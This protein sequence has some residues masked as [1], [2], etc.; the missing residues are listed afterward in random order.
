M[1]DETW[2]AKVSPEIKEELVQLVKESGLSSKEF[3]EQLLLEH[4]VALLQGTDA[5]RSED[6]QQVSYHLEKIKA[7]FVGLVEKSQDLKN[8]FNET[9]ERESRLHKEI[10]DQ[11]QYQVKQ[12][13]EERDKVI[14]DKSELEKRM[15]GIVARNEEL[16]SNNKAHLLTIQMQEEKIGQL[17]DR[18]G[19]IQAIE[20]EV[21]RLNQ[22]VQAQIKRIQDLEKEAQQYKREMEQA[23]AAKEV[24]E[25]DAAKA[26]EQ[27]AMSHKLELQSATLELE[28]RLHEENHKIKVEYF[29]KIETLTSKNQELTEKLHQLQLDQTKVKTKPAAVKEKDNKTEEGK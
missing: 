22:D 1:A 5:Q 19:A 13:Q 27:Q 6:I 3:L 23:Q 12:A 15:A 18:I 20:D 29:T 4:R 24:Q 11:Q 28:K 26:L 14:L 25:K 16:E 2:S 8:D 17:E 7:S 9:R 10:V 21:S